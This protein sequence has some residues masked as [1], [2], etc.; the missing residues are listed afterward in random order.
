[1]RHEKDLDQKCDF[2]KHCNKLVVGLYHIKTIVISGEVTI[3]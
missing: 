1:M 2:E 3:Y